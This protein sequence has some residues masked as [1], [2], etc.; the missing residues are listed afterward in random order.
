MMLVAGVN[1]CF[2]LDIRSLVGF[3]TVPKEYHEFKIT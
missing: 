1:R 2:S 3:R